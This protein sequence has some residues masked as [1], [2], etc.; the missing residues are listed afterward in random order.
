[1]LKCGE[2]GTGEV[3]R[4]VGKVGNQQ[5]EGEEGGGGEGGGHRTGSVHHSGGEHRAGWPEPAV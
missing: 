3:G 2:G 1:M 5:E 4:C